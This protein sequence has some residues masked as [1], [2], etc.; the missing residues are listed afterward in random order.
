MSKA[1]EDEPR[2]IYRAAA[3]SQRMANFMLKPISAAVAA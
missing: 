1:I 3:E 2:A